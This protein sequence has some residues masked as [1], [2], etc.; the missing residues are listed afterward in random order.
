MDKKI[1]K[2]LKNIVAEGYKLKAHHNNKDW[3]NALE[4]VEEILI[5]EKQKE[6]GSN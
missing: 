4:K 2:A 3:K 1:I 6:D 5:L